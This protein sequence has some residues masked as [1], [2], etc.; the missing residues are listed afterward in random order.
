[1]GLEHRLGLEPEIT[2]LVKFRVKFNQQL[3]NLEPEILIMLAIQKNIIPIALPC[4]LGIED[5]FKVFLSNIVER[6][7]L[8]FIIGNI[9]AWAIRQ[10]ITVPFLDN[11]T[12][13]EP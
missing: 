2:Q 1:V 6:I 8:D 3:R 12:G 10:K 5:P 13:R 9:A 11:H 7:T 4:A